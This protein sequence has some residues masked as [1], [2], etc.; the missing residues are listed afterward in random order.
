[1]GRTKRT[2]KLKARHNREHPIPPSIHYELFK[3]L[4]KL[5]WRNENRLAVTEFPSTGRGLRCKQSLSADDVIVELPLSSMITI[6]TIENDESFREVFDAEL[7]DC[8]VGSVNFQALLSLYL[9]HESFKS[10]SKWLPYL[11]TL[12]SSFTNPIFCAKNELYCLPDN[13]LQKIVEQNEMIKRNFQAL[14]SAVK[15]EHQPKFTLDAFKWS[16][17]V[18][19]TRS[20]FINGKMLELLC[21]NHRMFKEILSD[22]PNMALAPLLDLLNHSSD[23]ETKNHLLHKKC[24][25]DSAEFDMFYQLQTMKSIRKHD[26]VFINYGAHSN[27]KLLVEYG[28]FQPDNPVDFMEFTLEDINSY[29]KSHMQLKMQPIPKHKYKFIRDHELDQNVFIDTV[30]GLSHNFQAILCIL[31]LPYNMYNLEQ[32]AFGDDIDFKAI[33]AHA[34]GILERKK[35][36]LAKFIVGLVQLSNEHKLSASGKVCSEFL[37]ESMKFVDKVLKLI[38]SSVE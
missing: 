36:E 29:I 3:F 35:L 5:G 1:M 25:E 27:A 24:N 7:L 21:K 13:I 26:Q 20:V 6:A 14:M 30:D 31:I 4:A 9:Q 18:C 8:L 37:S 17:F 16:Y 12:P 34:R 19:N 2:R 15:G 38:S 11:R 10:D 32:V 33:E 28:F 22:P 23:A